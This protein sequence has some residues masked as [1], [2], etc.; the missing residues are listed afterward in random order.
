MSFFER[1]SESTALVKKATDK[2]ALLLIGCE[3]CGDKPKYFSY[4]DSNLSRK[5]IEMLK[6]NVGK[7]IQIVGVMT[8]SRARYP[9][10][11]IAIGE[12]EVN[13]WVKANE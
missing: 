7:Q 2:K 12:E 5:Q 13:E 1:Q 4:E 3:A 9:Q 10:R 6:N 8:S 11:L